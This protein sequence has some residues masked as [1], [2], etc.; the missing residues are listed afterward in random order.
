MV[1][2]TQLLGLLSLLPPIEGEGSPKFWLTAVRRGA[3]LRTESV[4][5]ISQLSPAFTLSIF[6][7][8]GSTPTSTMLSKP[9][10]LKDSLPP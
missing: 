1:P 3:L 5:P 2:A 7:L 6:F 4:R 10:R 8:N 9:A